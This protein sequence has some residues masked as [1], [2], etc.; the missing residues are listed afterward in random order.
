MFNPIELAWTGLKNYVRDKNVNF[1]L[2]NF[3]RLTD[4]WMTSLNRVI[5]VNYI[6]ETYKTRD[7]FKESDRLTRHVAVL[8]LFSVSH[9]KTKSKILNRRS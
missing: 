3:W 7:I 6:N 1:S 9:R 5:A 4:Q 2:S 8:F